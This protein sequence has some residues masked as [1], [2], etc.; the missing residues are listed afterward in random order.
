M[1]AYRVSCVGYLR[2]RQPAATIQYDKC[3][4]VGN[5]ICCETMGKG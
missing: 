2:L 4:Y 1:C 5:V 3:S